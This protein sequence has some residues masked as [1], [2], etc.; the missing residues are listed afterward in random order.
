MY[1]NGV[2]GIKVSMFDWIIFGFLSVW[3]ESYDIDFGYLFFDG[4]MVGDIKKYIGW[5]DIL[6]VCNFW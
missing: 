1:Y 3:V 6:Y 4:F 5:F 2:N